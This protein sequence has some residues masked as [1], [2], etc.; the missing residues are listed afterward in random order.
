[1][2]KDRT[3]NETYN[4]IISSKRGIGWRGV[5]KRGSAKEIGTSKGNI[6]TWNDMHLRAWIKSIMDL[7]PRL[8][9]DRSDLDS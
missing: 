6:M 7:L 9:S 2:G 1:M 4:D 5:L 3:E 8:V